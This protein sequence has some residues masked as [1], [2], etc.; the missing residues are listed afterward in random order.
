[1]KI[2]WYEQSLASW[3]KNYTFAGGEWQEQFPHEKLGSESTI[4]IMV[5][6][7]YSIGVGFKSHEEHRERCHKYSH[8]ILAKST[9]QYF[10]REC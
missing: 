7:A 5:T 9:A 6:V 8:K 10:Q 2:P 4:W 1:M 3:E